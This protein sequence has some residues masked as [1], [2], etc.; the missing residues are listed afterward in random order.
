[1]EQ[2][3]IDEINKLFKKKRNTLYRVRI[4]YIVY[5]DTINVFFEEQ[6]IGESTY[7]YS[8]GQFT[9]EMKEKMHDFAK[10]ITRETKGSAQ[11]F[12]L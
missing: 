4:V 7:S 1:M 6:K 5:T 9:G 11:L 2:I 12:N 8:I 10:R 3:V